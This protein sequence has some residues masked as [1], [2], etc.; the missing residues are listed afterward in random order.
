MLISN[1]PPLAY[2]II[3]AESIDYLDVVFGEQRLITGFINKIY[4]IVLAQAYSKIFC[5]LSIVQFWIAQ[6]D[7]PDLRSDRARLYSQISL[8]VILPAFFA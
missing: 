2:G 3:S 6:F 5:L 7:R 1:L 4:S 8:S